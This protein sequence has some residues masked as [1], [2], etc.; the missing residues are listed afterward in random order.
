MTVAPSGEQYE[1]R[2]GRQLLVATEVGANL[3]TYAVDGAP[4]LDGYAADEAATGARGQHLIPWPNRVRSGRYTFDG[5]EQQLALTEPEKAGAIHGLT[6]WATWSVRERSASAVTFEH[7]LHAQIGWSGVLDCTITLR[8]ADDG[9]T[10]TTTATNV[11]AVRCPY[12]TGAHPYLSVGSPQ[13]DADT[14]RVPG[15][16]YYPVDEAGIPTGCEDVAGT[17]YDLREPER[18]G[19]RH[20]DVAYTD[21][22]RDGDGRARVRMTA[23][24]GRA[25][26]LWV[27]D[28]YPYLEIFTGDT[29]PQPERHRT[30]LGCEP[31]TCA[32]NAF[33]SG[34]G[35]LV[36]EP[37]QTHTASW[38]IEPG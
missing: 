38:G 33:N 25:A 20:I 10:V 6:R 36:L 31:M 22:S 12:G 24:D 4:L 23:P 5:V 27:D 19:D 32:P 15:S 28:A 35:L 37:G 11:G 3:R 34:D 13:I 1:I 9:L 29:L 16:R 26:A 21:L 7:V 14:V 17:R 2:H 30:G 8:L 18:L